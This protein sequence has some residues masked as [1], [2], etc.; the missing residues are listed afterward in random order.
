MIL[1]ARREHLPCFAL[2]EVNHPADIPV[3][4]QFCDLGRCEAAGLRGIKESAH[5]ALIRRGK[6]ELEQ[7]LC[8]G[9]GHAFPCRAD[10]T[11][12]DGGL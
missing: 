12:E 2:D 8:R 11:F 9:P 1:A 10:D 7:R 6:L 4:F 5:A 3:I